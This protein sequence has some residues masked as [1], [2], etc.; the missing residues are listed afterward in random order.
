MKTNKKKDTYKHGLKSRK[1]YKCYEWEYLKMEGTILYILEMKAIVF[2]ISVRND[3]I[4]DTIGG[5]FKKLNHRA[6]M[7]F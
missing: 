4:L 7:V 1:T 6:V 5:G 2:K 3:Y